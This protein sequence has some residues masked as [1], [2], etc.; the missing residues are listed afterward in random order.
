MPCEISLWVASQGN[1]KDLKMKSEMKSGMI[2]AVVGD[3]AGSRF[4]W[5]NQ[6][7]ILVGTL[8]KGLISGYVR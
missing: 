8:Q 7:W 5:H 2:G 1:R 3:I 4:E 6:K